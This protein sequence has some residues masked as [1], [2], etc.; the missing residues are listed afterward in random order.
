MK[1]RKL[2]DVVAWRMCLG[3]GACAYI[4]PE[5]KVSLVDFIDEGIRPVLS[6]E[7]CGDCTLCLQ[8]CPA[9]QSDFS[10]TAKASANGGG[11][12]ARS[13]GPVLEIWEGHAADPGIRF[14]G[15]SGGVLTAIAAY[16]LER[17]GMRGV[18][19]VGQDEA[20]PVRNRTRLSR[21][22][23]DLMAAVGSRYS[24]ASVCDGLG[25]VEQ[26]P[27]PCVVIGKPAEIAAVR[28]ARKLR[29]ALAENIGL[30][31]S[32]FCAETPST[33]GTLELLKKM[34]I[35]PA[36][37]GRLSYRGEGWPGHFAPVRQ[38]Q[39]E[40]SAKMTYRESWSFL[41]RYRP[42]SVQLWP[43]G[44]GEL[45][46]I[47]CGD[48]WYKEPDG[49]SPGSSLVVVRT[50]RGQKIIREA[51][52][53]G[54]LE[55]TPAEPWKLEKSQAGLISKKG[56]VWGRRL[57]LRL[58]RL[59]VSRLDGLDLWNIWRGL[60]P[61]DKLRSTLGTVRRVLERKLCRPLL[62][63]A[64]IRQERSRQDVSLTET[65]R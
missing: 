3:C 33:R 54:Y 47:T 60:P 61:G 44:T 30:T 51:I 26:G 15:S 36:N 6:N 14:K 8:V 24:P 32:F 39:S 13:W 12:F 10:D 57:G 53:A 11:D 5:R 18:L 20:N 65:S 41:Q 9:V 55:L 21:T 62:L 43:D 1:I 40:P 17:G 52:R 64:Q 29:P 56:A 7:Q 35:E 25:Q 59:P 23:A 2:S 31:L 58:F 46:D 28:N 4:C 22:R 45:A 49:K 48:P 38:G 63:A 16:C 42:W 50:E 27:G 37:L 19:Q 34:G